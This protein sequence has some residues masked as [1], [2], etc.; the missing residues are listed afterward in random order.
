MTLINPLI[1]RAYDIR[2]IAFTPKCDKAVDLTPETVGLIGKAAGTYIQSKFGPNIVVGGDNRL[3]TPELKKAYINGLLSTGCHVT[4]IGL[5]TSPM[6]Y[7]AT[8]KLEMDGGT[9]ITASHNPKQYNGV[10][11]VGPMAHAI[12]GDALQE[13]LCIIEEGAFKT[14]EGSY[15][16]RDDIFDLYVADMKEKIEITKPLKVV[17]DAGNGIAGKFAGDLF[18][19]FGCEVTEL[20][21]ELDGN[22]PNHEANPEDEENLLDMIELMKTGKYDIGVGF[23]GDGDR[24]G[25]V[26]EKGKHYAAD[27]HLLL[28]AKDLLERHPRSHVVF[29]VKASQVVPQTIREHSGEP[30]MAKTGHSFIEKTMHEKGALLAGEVSGHLFFAE[31]YYGFDDAFLAA[32]KTF[33]ILARHEI[34]FSEHF[35]NLPKTH[36]TPEI[37]VPCPDES[38][39]EV[40]KELRDHFEKEYDCITIDGVRIIFDDTT[41]GI[42][43][44]SNTTPNLT[45]RFEALDPERLAEVMKIVA[46]V[47]KQHDVVDMSW[48]SHML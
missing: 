20:Y 28:L 6:L 44:C 4:D 22:F 18:R 31:D 47:M 34:P 19:A 9:N 45:M 1:F 12:C 40:V 3:S 10:K 24:I 32:L 25:I 33:S 17:V 36:A 7:Y 5:A 43:R 29:D 13:V 21:C 11:L 23:D 14:G 38:K 48:A 2:G 46:N 26:D 41:W 35:A 30:I 39:F 27:L 42:I 8:C 15:V 16:Q 37:K